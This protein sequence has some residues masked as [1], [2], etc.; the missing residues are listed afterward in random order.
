M[1]FTEIRDL[2]ENNKLVLPDFQRNFVWDS[3]K[4]KNNHKKYQKI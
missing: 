4:M 3:E 1:K 2:I